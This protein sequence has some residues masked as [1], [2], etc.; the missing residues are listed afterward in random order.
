MGIIP[1][2][3]ASIIMQLLTFAIPSWQEMAKEGESGRK[4]IAQYTRYLTTGLALVQSTGMSIVLRNLHAIGNVNYSATTNLF[5][6]IQVDLLSLTAGTAFLM[7]LGEQITDKGIG[8][9]VS[10]IIFL[11]HHGASAG[12]A[13][14]CW[15]SW[16]CPASIAPWQ[17]L[18]AGCSVLCDSRWASSS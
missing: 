3:N 12:P 7:W 14:Q 4:R 6:L 10:L 11:W 16:R 1:Y 15:Q 9:G 13:I 8:N 2:I 18:L 17:V 5:L